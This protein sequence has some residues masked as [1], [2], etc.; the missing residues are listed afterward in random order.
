MLDGPGAWWSILRVTVLLMALVIFA[1]MLMRRFVRST[2]R[3]GYRLQVVESIACG[4][5]R[6]ICVVRCDE[7]ELI[8]GVTDAQ[9]TVLAEQ[10]A[11]DFCEAKAETSERGSLVERFKRMTGKTSGENTP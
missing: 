8:L 6:L 5:N 7:R 9:I 1:P 2:G 10:D 11:M 4:G 3:G